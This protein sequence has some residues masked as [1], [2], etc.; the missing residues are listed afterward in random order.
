MKR[1]VVLALL[2]GAMD[3]RAQTA[4]PAA[5]P[6]GS[7]APAPTAPS[8]PAPAAPPPAEAA[9]AAE[10]PPPPAAE[11]PAATPPSAAAAA[12]APTPAPAPPPAPGAAPL[13]GAAPAPYASAPYPPWYPAYA[14]RSMLETELS[15]LQR[16]RAELS[17]G[18]PIAAVIAGGA[19]LA[20]SAV[21]LLV[22][23]AVDNN[24]SYY[25]Y[26]YSYYEDDYR[27]DDGDATTLYIVGGFGA[28][29]GGLTLVYGIFRL[30]DRGSERRELGRRMK[31]IRRELG[32][33]SQA[34][35]DVRLGIGSDRA[36]LRLQARF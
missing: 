8:T 6:A 32:Y 23:V 36:G 16:R 14:R 4:P 3:A 27:C 7:T 12:P 24:C 19:V 21:L 25:D 35:L 30:V 1:F 13:P 15:D 2:L 20:V 18:G 9:P 17:L 22:A 29:L 5:A 33:G 34:A 26:D 31:E 11:S 10:V 28:V